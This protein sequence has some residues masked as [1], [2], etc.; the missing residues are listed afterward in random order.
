MRGW[1]ANVSR[2]YL[3]TF[4][5]LW[6]YGII[7]TQYLE[8]FRKKIS[9]L[10]FWSLIMRRGPPYG[11]V[12]K[13]LREYPSSTAHGMPTASPAKRMGKDLVR[14]VNCRAFSLMTWALSVSSSRAS[15]IF[16]AWAFAEAP[17]Y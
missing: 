1:R 17:E 6:L 4:L 9:S 12:A 3:T 8:M 14:L 15:F 7:G 2:S 13:L 10:E 11:Q 16:V 5:P